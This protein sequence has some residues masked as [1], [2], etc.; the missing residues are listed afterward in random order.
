[1]WLFRNNTSYLF[2]SEKVGVLGA[3]KPTMSM[4]GESH[5]VWYSNTLANVSKGG[6]RTTYC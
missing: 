3:L 5:T 1:M 4:Q 6:D 2:S